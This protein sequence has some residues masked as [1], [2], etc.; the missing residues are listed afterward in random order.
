MELTLDI[1]PVFQR[2]KKDGLV[3]DQEYSIHSMITSFMFA[4]LPKILFLHPIHPNSI[5][6]GGS[7]SHSTTFMKIYLTETIPIEFLILRT[8]RNYYICFFQL[9]LFVIKPS[10]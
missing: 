7:N 6:S 9:L 5:L 3:T 10:Q 1:F 8:P 4:S 2:G